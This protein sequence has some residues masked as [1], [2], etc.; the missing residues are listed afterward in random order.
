[1][2]G[3]P[4]SNMS[5]DGA[6]ALTAMRRGVRK[7]RALSIQTGTPFYVWKNGKVVD[8]NA[9][10]KKKRSGTRNAT[11]EIRCPRSS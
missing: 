1:M 3:I 4:R 8:L 11:K 6:K 9:T 7:A 5:K 2:R 10:G